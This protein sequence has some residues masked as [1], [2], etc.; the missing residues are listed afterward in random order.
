[1]VCAWGEER[2]SI[3][4]KKIKRATGKWG[5]DKVKPKKSI[6]PKFPLHSQ[7]DALKQKKGQMTAA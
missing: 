1:M 5:E 6:T 7:R 2:L 4:F 3:R